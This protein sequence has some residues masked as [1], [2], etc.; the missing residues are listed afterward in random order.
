MVHT[1]APTAGV[2]PQK[3]A[4]RIQVPAVQGW[5]VYAKEACIGWY[6]IRGS[7]SMLNFIFLAEAI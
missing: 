2:H 7:I 1:G 4:E 6:F 3:P 5:L